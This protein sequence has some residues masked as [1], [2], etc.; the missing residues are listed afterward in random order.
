MDKLAE[1][2]PVQPDGIADSGF[3]PHS[4]ERAVVRQ[5]PSPK[6]SLFKDWQADPSLYGPEDVALDHNRTVVEPQPLP[7][8]HAQGP[9]PLPAA[10][11]ARLASVR[12]SMPPVFRKIYPRA[13]YARTGNPR[14]RLP[15]PDLMWLR[16][17]TTLWCSLPPVP[18][19]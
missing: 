18:R 6:P 8:P 19:Q 14:F 12:T 17:G 7:L 15:P 11:L 9:P 5:K 2:I 16:P 10:A 3:C 13:A 1:I 4:G